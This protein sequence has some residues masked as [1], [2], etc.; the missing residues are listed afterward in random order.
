MR[1]GCC[2]IERKKEVAF[3]THRMV[4]LPSPPSINCA[5]LNGDPVEF[6]VAHLLS[7]LMY[8]FALVVY[9]LIF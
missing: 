9:V 2:S 7:E 3:G 4:S 6:F 1:E 8:L 5:I